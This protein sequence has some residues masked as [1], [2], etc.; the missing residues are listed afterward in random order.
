MT[1]ADSAKTLNWARN[2][3]FSAARV[4]RPESLD[5]LR[6]AVAAARSVRALGSGHSF[7]RIADTADTLVSV[8]GLPRE[9]TVTP[10]S[11]AAPA[12]ARVSAG[13][14]YS[15]I[16]E[17]IHAAGY[18]LAN[19]A[20]LPHISVAGAVATGTHGS[21]NALGNLATA[22]SALRM[23][24]PGG[25]VIE[26]GRASDPDRFDGAVVALGALGVVTEVV[27]DLVPTFDLAQ[28]VYVGL[29]L[30]ALAA[31][32][33]AIFAA[34]YSVS[35]FTNWQSGTADVWVKQRADATREPAPEPAMLGAL[36]ADRPRHPVPAQPAENV[37]ELDVP[38]PWFAR[39]PHFRPEFTPSSGEELQ[40]EFFL[41]R[42][43]VPTAL[44]ELRRLGD[45]LAPVL[46]ISELRTIAADGLWL[47][48]AYGR[49]TASF[50]FTWIEDAGAV[51]P[52]LDAV[53][54][55]LLPLGARPHWGKVFH[56]PPSQ[57]SAMYEH[58]DDFR[59]LMRAF[60]P[61]GKFRNPFVDGFFPPEA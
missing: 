55:R 40:S 61:E 17:P 36:L 5:E 8:A 14:R 23:V 43:A 44:D 29:P 26:L 50:H 21:G 32:P 12:T 19:M 34:A 16:A 2:I 45:R 24:G 10:A 38:G 31:Q 47:S 48:P 53:E 7:N 56:V 39:L 60:D 1:T 33:A 30:D 13:L 4:H 41:D 42:A 15:E 46:Q 22:V 59:G 58:A 57:V 20:S 3:T 54:E 37:T 18:A 51:D 25:D 9:V 35:V 11:Q 27:L 52:V 28:H 6:R 49:D